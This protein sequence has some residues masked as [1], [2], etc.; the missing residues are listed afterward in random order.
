LRLG[1][2]GA[3]IMFNINIGGYGFRAGAARVPE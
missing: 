2:D 1:H 3:A